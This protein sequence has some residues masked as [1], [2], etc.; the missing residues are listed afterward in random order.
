MAP[1]ER[2]DV[3]LLGFESLRQFDRAEIFEKGAMHE[4]VQPRTAQRQDPV[5]LFEALDHFARGPAFGASKRHSC[6]KKSSITPRNVASLIA[7][8]RSPSGTSCIRQ[9]MRRSIS[10]VSSA[11]R[12]ISGLSGGRPRPR[13]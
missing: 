5:A 9:A 13:R 4:P 2:V 11:C 1:N 12:S 3:E 10:S 7:L 8:A 6:S